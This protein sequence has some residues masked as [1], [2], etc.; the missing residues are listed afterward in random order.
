[1]SKA[2]PRAW[3]A[4][5]W[6]VGAAVIALAVRALVK[7]WADLRTQPLTLEPRPL[8]LLAS[9]LIVGAMYAILIASWRAMLSGWGQRL[10]P[11]TAARI[12]TVSNLGKY[13]PGKVWALAGMT[14][15]SQR[16]GVAPWAAAASAVVL[17]AVGIATG[18]AL[19]G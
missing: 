4:V 19:V 12:W 10:D 1:M 11:W 8:Y 15:L 9:A 18:A 3:R 2:A 17:Q 7:N 16:A 14:L 13:L 5:Q 6:V